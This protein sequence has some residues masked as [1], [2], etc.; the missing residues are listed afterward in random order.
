MGITIN[1]H[2]IKEYNILYIKYTIH[3]I[4]YGYIHKYVYM[5][6]YT[7]TMIMAL[8]MLGLGCV[9]EWKRL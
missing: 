4:N 8:E 3:I 5:Y 9:P 2:F 1:R 7:S 6:L